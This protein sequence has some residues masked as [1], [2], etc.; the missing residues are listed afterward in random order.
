MT[1]YSSDER[2]LEQAQLSDQEPQDA[3]LVQLGRHAKYL[4]GL[5]EVNVELQDDR[6]ILVP[7]G[8]TGRSFSEAPL[9]AQDRVYQIKTALENAEQ[10]YSFT[11]MQQGDGSEWFHSSYTEDGRYM[12]QPYD[13]AA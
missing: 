12:E 8:E 7:V 5:S 6:R 4:A 1:D 3:T 10:A 13:T 11:S 9:T 2:F